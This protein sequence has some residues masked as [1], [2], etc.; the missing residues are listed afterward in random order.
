MDSPAS[1][2]QPHPARLRRQAI[3]TPDV[4]LPY[5]PAPYLPVPAPGSKASAWTLTSSNHFTPG[6]Q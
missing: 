2:A 5:L 1:H 4:P 3:P 6:G